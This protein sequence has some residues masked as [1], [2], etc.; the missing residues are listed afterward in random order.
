[1][2]ILLNTIKK[3]LKIVDVKHYS[4]QFCFSED[5]TFENRL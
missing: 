2:I 3:F 4:K 5:I 1:M